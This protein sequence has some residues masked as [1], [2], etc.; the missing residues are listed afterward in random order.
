MNSLLCSF[1]FLLC[2]SLH[3]TL[4]PLLRTGVIH[5]EVLALYFMSPV[6]LSFYASSSTRC[7]GTAYSRY[8]GILFEPNFLLNIRLRP[9]PNSIF[10]STSSL[11]WRLMNN[12]IILRDGISENHTFFAGQKYPGSHLRST[13]FPLFSHLHEELQNLYMS[14]EWRL[15]VWNLNPQG[16]VNYYTQMLYVSSRL[17]GRLSTLNIC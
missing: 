11:G 17:V 12:F 4:Y 5:P 3:S 7:N 14:F 15:L 8:V 1:P 2:A 10:Y 13:H 16:I 6:L 9:D